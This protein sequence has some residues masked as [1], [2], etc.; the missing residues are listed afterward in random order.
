MMVGF[1]P[2]QLF[3]LCGDITDGVR[4]C[5][6][7]T[8]TYNLVRATPVVVSVLVEFTVCFVI[9]QLVNMALRAIVKVH[10]RGPF[11]K[12]NIGSAHVLYRLDFFFEPVLI[13]ILIMC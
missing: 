11:D 3:P 6:T 2:R 10:K 8:H 4:P 1:L 13:F 12:T 9:G 7:H 5:H